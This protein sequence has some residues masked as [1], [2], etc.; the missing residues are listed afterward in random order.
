MVKYASAC[1]ARIV[2]QY[3]LQLHQQVAHHPYISV[4]SI[5]H[6]KEGDGIERYGA[7]S[8]KLEE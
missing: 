7:L 3:A 2:L 1:I 5:D 6:P 8:K 4:F